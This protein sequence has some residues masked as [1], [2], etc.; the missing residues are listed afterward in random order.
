MSFVF[1]SLSNFQ[2]VEEIRVMRQQIFT[3]RHTSVH[4]L[5]KV[6]KHQLKDTLGRGYYQSHQLAQRANSVRILFRLRLDYGGS[7]FD[8]RQ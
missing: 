1:H 7:G 6:Y 3:L 2:C 8:S 5:I 4:V